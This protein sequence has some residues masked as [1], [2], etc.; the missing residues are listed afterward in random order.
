[1]THCSLIFLLH[2]HPPAVDM[3]CCPTGGNMYSEKDLMHS[4]QTLGDHDPGSCMS[5]WDK[6]R[7]MRHAI[8]IR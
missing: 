3:L 7:F 6:T 2:K 4:T 5:K 8:V 1:M